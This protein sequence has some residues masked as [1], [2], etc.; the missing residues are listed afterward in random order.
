MDSKFIIMTNIVLYVNAV[1]QRSETLKIDC[2]S[3]FATTR[4][5]ELF[6]STAIHHDDRAHM[7]TME[8]FT[9]CFYVLGF[10]L[11]TYR[12]ADEEHKCAASG[13]YAYRSTL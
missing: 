10:D 9:K 13:N 11:T 12:E 7:I 6:S 3:P 1:Q 8:L 4:A 5:C 2:S